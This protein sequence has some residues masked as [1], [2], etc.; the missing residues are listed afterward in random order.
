MKTI[1]A[2]ITLSICIGQKTDAQNLLPSEPSTTYSTNDKM[3]SFTPESKALLGPKADFNIEFRG[4]NCLVVNFINLS[5]NA[6]KYRW[7]FGDGNQSTRFEPLHVYAQDGTYPVKL[8]IEKGEAKDSITLNVQVQKKCAVGIAEI[9]TKKVS[10]SPNPITHGA[11]ITYPAELIGGQLRI[12]DVMGK[13]IYYQK[14]GTNLMTPIERQA[15]WPT[16]IYYLELVKKDLRIG[17][18]IVL[19]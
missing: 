7:D 16:G 8:A 12:Y 18:K 17:Q 3:V 14:L 5:E 4:D 10:L 11:T 9:L 13:Q 2:L 6:V 1:L 19:Q 15:D